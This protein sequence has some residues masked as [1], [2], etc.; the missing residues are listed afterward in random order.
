M[1]RSF[2]AIAAVVAFAMSGAVFAAKINLN[3]ADAAT[4][5][6]GIDGVGPTIAERIVAWRE[7][8]GPFESIDQLVEVRGIG[9]KTLADNRENLSVEASSE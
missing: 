7:A 3:T 6:D 8:N 9:E 5:A 4:L 2:L 1:K